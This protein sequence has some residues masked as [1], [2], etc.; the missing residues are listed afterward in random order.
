MS[1]RASSSDFICP[2]PVARTTENGVGVGG[3]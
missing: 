1:V 3:A 2:G